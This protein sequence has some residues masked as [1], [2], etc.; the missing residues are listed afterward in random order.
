MGSKR[1]EIPRPTCCDGAT[2]RREEG[3]NPK[4]ERP[5][6]MA[7]GPRPRIWCGLVT[8]YFLRPSDFGLL[9]DFGLR[10]SELPE[11]QKVPQL[12][13]HLHGVAYRAGNFAFNHVAK[14]P[15]ETMNGDLHRA[16]VQGELA[17][18]VG[19]RDVFGVA[20][21]PGFERFELDG[22]AAGSVFL[23]EGS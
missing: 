7:P 3:R 6:F 16:F 12:F 23:R 15:A 13:V 22:F 10:I 21:Q 11:C 19:L 20:C 5:G 4:S 9:S 2:T 8:S 14:S 1:G 17:G 18:G